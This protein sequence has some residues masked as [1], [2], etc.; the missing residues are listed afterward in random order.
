MTESQI[1]AVVEEMARELSRC[2]FVA[3]VVLGGSRAT[4]TAAPSSDVDMGIYY[5]PDR[6]EVPVLSRI[7]ARFDDAHRENLVCREGEWGP[8]VNCGGWLTVGG[9]PVDWILR[10]I[11]RVEQVLQETEEGKISSHYQT[12]H[13]HAYLNVM[14]RGEL[15]C[16]KL[17]YARD[18]AFREKKR[19]AESYPESMGRAL[20]DF[21]LFESGFSCMLAEK[22]LGR[23]DSYYV[24]G[25]LFRAVS[26][27]NQ[28][29]FALN[30]CYY[31]NEKKAVLRA[32]ALPITV[33]GYRERV[34]AVFHPEDGREESSVRVLEALCREVRG[35][36][37]RAAAGGEW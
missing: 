27:L 18:E 21:F 36:A 2:P 3:G 24:T 4:G 6:L 5:D 10:D 1:A 29:L 37:E 22:H 12:G 15:A 28:V 26:V 9:V 35:L 33:P 25:H 19:Q 11:G 16:G 31:L 7:A 17:L 32:G 8:W 13:P 23:E 30:R 34:E 20:L 14:Y